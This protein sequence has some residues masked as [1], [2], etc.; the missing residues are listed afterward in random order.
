[1]PSEDV[2]VEQRVLSQRVIGQRILPFLSIIDRWSCFQVFP[3]WRGLA[4]TPILLARGSERSRAKIVRQL[5]N[6]EE[7]SVLI[8][9][10]VPGFVLFYE[11]VCHLYLT[12]SNLVSMDLSTFDLHITDL[13]RLFS[14]DN[15]IAFAS[16]ERISATVKQ[17]PRLPYSNDDAD[18]SP[19][20]PNPVVACPALR[21]L[22]V[23]FVPNLQMN[24]TPLATLLKIAANATHLTLRDRDSCRARDRRRHF[25][26]YV[27][28]NF[29]RGFPNLRELSV[30]LYTEFLPA[31]LVETNG[32][33]RCWFPVLK[34]LTI[35]GCGNFV[36]KRDF[37]DLKNLFDDINVHT[38]PH[39]QFI[40]DIF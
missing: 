10:D 30:S 22:D 37:E 14:G 25:S 39:T 32:D 8:V 18:A 21:R 3:T 12:G 24:S 28:D 36:N 4:P 9:W 29:P 2:P 26:W 5:T 23:L 1:M 11:L 33:Y 19:W 6:R 17:T 40:D 35:Y 31:L 16:L 20:C 27:K 15:Q 13:V 38:P 7:Q 34:D